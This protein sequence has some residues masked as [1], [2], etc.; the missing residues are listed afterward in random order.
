MMTRPRGATTPR[1]VATSEDDGEPR[2]S[3]HWLTP[4]HTLR[5]PVGFLLLGGAAVLVLVIGAYVV[6]YHMAD[7][8]IQ[9]EY[10]QALLDR[11]RKT[12][13]AQ[14]ARD[15]LNA[16]APVAGPIT[17][18]L[19]RQEQT[20]AAP[21]MPAGWGPVTPAEGSDPRVVGLHYFIVAETH[22]DGALRLAQF[23]RSQ[24]LEAYVVPAH[25]AARRRVI[26]LPGF[27][28]RARTNADV[29]RLEE[30]IFEV[31]AQWKAAERGAS[32]LRDAYMARYDG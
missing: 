18:P 19:G 14:A 7:R 10:D 5:V 1:P 8:A 3:L 6:G 27:E 30:R 20:T 24:G 17:P 4:G 13:A 22:P 26:I 15:P 28:T 25:N 21:Q 23:C 16:P 2:L 9:S 32:D 11:S 29:E 31:G 12:A